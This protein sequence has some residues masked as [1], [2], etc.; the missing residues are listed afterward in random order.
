MRDSGNRI[1]LDAK[2]E[3]RTRQDSLYRRFDTGLEIP[4]PP[5]NFVKTHDALLICSSDGPAVR[6][7]SQGRNDSSGA[8]ALVGSS[9]GP[10]DKNPAAA[11]R[12][13]RARS[14]ERTRDRERLNVGL[15]GPVKVVYGTSQIALQST[16]SGCLW[17]L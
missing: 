14:I 6:P 8:R 11:R 7:A 9:R 16:G 5:S 2:D 12:V 3:L 13:T 15:P 4:F 1:V 10:A 17:F